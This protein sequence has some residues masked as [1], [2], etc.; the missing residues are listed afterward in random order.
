M[1]WKLII[2]LNMAA[3]LNHHCRCE[4]SKLDYGIDKRPS[5]IKDISVPLPEPAVSKNYILYL[6]RFLAQQGIP[7]KVE[8][9]SLGDPREKSLFLAIILP[10]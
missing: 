1:T 6:N 4:Y 9:S 7:T 10:K 8:T 2:I 3:R 5:T